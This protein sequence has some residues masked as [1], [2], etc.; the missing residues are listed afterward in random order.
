MITTGDMHYNSDNQAVAAVI[1][2]GLST[3]TKP[4]TAV[5][6]GSAFIEMDTSSLF[7]FDE[8][9]TEWLE[10][11]AAPAS[12]SVAALTANPSLLNGKADL[13][14]VNPSLNEEEQEVADDD[15]GP[16]EE[17]E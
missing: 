1:Y 9:S 6:N 10:W 7:F 17:T 2:Y 16:E 13:G 14:I 8:S 11:G 4:T 5:G 3:D 15:P 12:S